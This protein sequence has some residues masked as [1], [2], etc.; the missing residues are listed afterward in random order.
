MEEIEGS[1]F[2]FNDEEV[3]EATSALQKGDIRPLLELV[4]DGI[5]ADAGEHVYSNFNESNIRTAVKVLALYGAGYRAL[6]E[7]DLAGPG[8]AD[9]ILTPSNGNGASYLLELKYLKKSLAQKKVADAVENATKEA[10]EQLKRYCDSSLVKEIKDIKK[11][12]AVFHGA[13]LVSLKSL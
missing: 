7:P 2:T 4:S 11:V 9:L 5:Y 13:Q 10:T 8:Y 1:H 3:I 12:A 6:E